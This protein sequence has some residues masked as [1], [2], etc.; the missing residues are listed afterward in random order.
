MLY[1][2]QEMDALQDHRKRQQLHIED[3]MKSHEKHN[4]HLTATLDK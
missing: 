4:K 2:R 3:S 1:F